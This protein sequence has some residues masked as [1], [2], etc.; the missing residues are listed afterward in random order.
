MLQIVNAKGF[1]MTFTNGWTVSVQWGPMNY[2]ENRSYDF[3]AHMN[4]PEDLAS[5]D[6]EVAAW[7]ADGNWHDFGTDQVKGWC[8]ANEV[9]DFITFIAGK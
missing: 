4:I 5:Q 2:C 3:N 8:T 6:A 1:R 9:A 7:D